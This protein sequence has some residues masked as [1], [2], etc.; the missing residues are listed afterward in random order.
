TTAGSGLGDSASAGETPLP[1]L[2]AFK[3]DSKA[4]VAA[5]IP[6]LRQALSRGKF[7]GRRAVLCLPDDCLIFRTLRLA[8]MPEPELLSAVQWKMATELSLEPSQ[9]ICQIVALNPVTEST[10]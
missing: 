6:L 10:R 2:A 3:S 8:E 5:A 7:R 9:L 1:A 4:A